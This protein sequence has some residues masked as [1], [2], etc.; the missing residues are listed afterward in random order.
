VRFESKGRQKHMTTETT[1]GPSAKTNHGAS[2]WGWLTVFAFTFWPAFLYFLGRRLGWAKPWRWVAALAPV[3]LFVII[4]I[5]AGG[6]SSGDTPS[7]TPPPASAPAAA[8]N[9]PAPPPPAAKAPSETV[10]Q[11]NARESAESYLD[12]QAF[13]RQGLIRQLSSSA[14][15]GFSRADAIY[16]VNHIDV[17]WN[18]Q[19]AKAAKQYLETQSFS[20]AGLIRQLESSAGEGFT[21]A[22]AVYGVNQTGL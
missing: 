17:D 20:R 19:A 12:Y 14:G 8:A 5:A 3:A 4:I 1:H 18:E 21:H 7:A 2:S 16:A 11:K 13:S 6:G 10:S 22:Q 15:E 9:P